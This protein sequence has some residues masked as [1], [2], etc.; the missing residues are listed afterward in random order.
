MTA[1]PVR[2][3]TSDEVVVA[4]TLVDILTELVATVVVEVVVVIGAMVTMIAGV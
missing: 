3:S 2:G 4:G 1:C